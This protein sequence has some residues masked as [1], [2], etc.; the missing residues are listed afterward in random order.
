MNVLVLNGSDTLGR[1]VVR[2]LTARGAQVTVF[3]GDL[4]NA[5]EV[6]AAVSNCSAVF[7]ATPSSPDQVA[8]QNIAVDAA[9]DVGAKVVKLSEWGP[10]VRADSPVPAARRHWITQQYILK[11]RIPYTFLQPN[12]LAQSIVDQYADQVRSAGRLGLPAGYRGVSMVD[13]RDVAEVAACSLLDPAHDGHTYVLTGPSAP[14]FA[15]VAQALSEMTGREIGYEDLTED[16]FAERAAAAGWA[17]WEIDNV[18][19][20][21]RLYRDGAGELVTDDV[22]RVTGRPARTLTDVLQQHRHAFS[23]NLRYG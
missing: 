12:R 21:F 6:R 5:E 11:R 1:E 8:C 14:T 18:L 17:Q 20:T 16:R 19:E 23:D 15:E 10:A 7:L 3:D 22:Q 4:T 13:A 9:T 2:S